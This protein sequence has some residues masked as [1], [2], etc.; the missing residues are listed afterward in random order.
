M[1]GLACGLNA[2]GCGWAVHHRERAVN[3]QAAVWKVAAVL[4]VSMVAWATG[5]AEGHAASA[6]ARLLCIAAGLVLSALD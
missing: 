6:A 1:A 3:F 2:G 4:L 5:H